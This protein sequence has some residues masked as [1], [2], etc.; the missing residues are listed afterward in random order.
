LALCQQGKVTQQAG[1]LAEQGGELA[2]KAL[3]NSLLATLVAPTLAET[4][5]FNFDLSDPPLPEDSRESKIASRAIVK[6]GPRRP[7]SQSPYQ[8]G[9]A[10]RIQRAIDHEWHRLVR[11]HKSVHTAISRLTGDAHPRR[12]KQTHRKPRTS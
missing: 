12:F 4:T 10:L 2:E 3:A 8:V 1:E 6:G 5:N 11:A 9:P 7:Q